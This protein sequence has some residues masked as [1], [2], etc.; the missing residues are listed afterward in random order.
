MKR[1]LYEDAFALKTGKAREFRQ[2]LATHEEKLR[3]ACPDGVDYLG[4][5]TVVHTTD[6]G[7]GD[8]RVD[9]GIDTY[10]AVDALAAAME[11][12][13]PLHVLLDEMGH[14]AERDRFRR[15]T[16]R[17][18][19]TAMGQLRSGQ[20]ASAAA[21]CPGRRLRVRKGP[22]ADADEVSAHDEQKATRS[23]M[24]NGLVM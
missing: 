8:V 13:G 18:L 20:S 3:L 7:G 14:F 19:L 15:G 23:L 17:T 1:Y 6:D 12:P 4:T 22:Q 10:S 21:P 24:S 2:W 16:N 5:Y 11:E 9:W